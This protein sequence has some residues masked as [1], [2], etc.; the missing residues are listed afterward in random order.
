MSTGKA[1]RTK[2]TV[3]AATLLI[4]IGKWNASTF[5]ARVLTL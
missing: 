5:D 3:L 1:G 4:Q 2:E